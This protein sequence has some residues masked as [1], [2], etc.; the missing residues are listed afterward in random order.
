MKL[1][2]FEY[3]TL[4]PGSSLLSEGFNMLKSVLN[5]LDNQSFFE[6]TYL[7]NPKLKINTS[8][9]KKIILKSNLNDWLINYS[10]N[11]DYC[12]FIAP[13]DDLIQYNITKILE[14][15]DVKII[16]SNS[17][18]SYICSS[19]FLTY[20]VVPSTILKIPTC[21]I[22]FKD[23][24]NENIKAIVKN[25]TC[26]MKPDNKTSSELIY[27]IKNF[28]DFKR[29][30]KIYNKKSIDSCLLQEYIP[31]KSYSVSLIKN[32]NQISFLSVN[33]QN[34]IRNNEQLRYN[35]CKTPLNHPLKEQLFK[36]SEEIVNNIDGL[37]GFIG[38]DFIIQDKTI[39]FVEINSRLTTPYIILQEL[40]EKNLTLFL[41]D[42]VI[43]NRTCE[44]NFKDKKTFTLN[45]GICE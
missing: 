13:E 22:N 43:N 27:I 4:H 10:S 33:S 12:L 8:F 38:I 45:K 37:L 6:V 40:C 39:Y 14:K 35:G 3:S 25:N 24:N 30:V 29:T 26:I 18:A 34:I 42:N 31:G 32:K 15:C 28:D 5:D 41:L 7:I 11:Y 21:K 23:I 9:C 36:I 17:E 1:L 20:T 2:V 44:I 19:K 16:G